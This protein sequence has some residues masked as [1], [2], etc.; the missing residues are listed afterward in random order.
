MNI[1]SQ[2]DFHLLNFIINTKH[3]PFAITIFNSFHIHCNFT[4]CKINRKPLST[5]K[6]FT[7]HIE[8]QRM[9]LKLSQS[10]GKIASHL[11]GFVMEMF[12][13]RYYILSGATAMAFWN[14]N[15]G[16]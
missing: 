2:N 8:N 11:N 13:L 6:Q 12:D 10:I 1:T 16:Q 7:N 14:A 3:H 15:I 5:A 4:E 9:E